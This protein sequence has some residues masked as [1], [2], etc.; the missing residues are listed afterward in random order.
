ME[1][2]Y[3]NNKDLVKVNTSI[4]SDNFLNGSVGDVMDMSLSCMGR[5]MKAMK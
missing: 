3:S 5:L 4:M 2:V 1:R